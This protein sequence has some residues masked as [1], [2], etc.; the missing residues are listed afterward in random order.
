HRAHR[1]RATARDCPY[2]LVL[3]SPI[4]VPTSHRATA[5]DCPY[6][7]VLLS[8]VIVPTSR[9]ATARDCPYPSSHAAPHARPDPIDPPVAP[10]R[11][12]AMPCSCSC[13]I[14]IHTDTPHITTKTFTKGRQAGNN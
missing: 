12:W 7:S 1:L 2:H 10:L 13:H 11:G 3:L 14:L 8:P 6:H 9:R 4:I 5:R